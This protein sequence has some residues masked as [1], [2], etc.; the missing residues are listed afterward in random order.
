MVVIEKIE[1]IWENGD[2]LV[3]IKASKKGRSPPPM[4]CRLLGVTFIDIWKILRAFQVGILPY[5][6]F[7]GFWSFGIPNPIGLARFAPKRLQKGQIS[8]FFD[9]FHKNDEKSIKCQAQEGFNSPK[10]P[11]FN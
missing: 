1:K 3:K 8:P 4:G 2:F 7:I 6:V 10:R 9:C 5:M 11:I